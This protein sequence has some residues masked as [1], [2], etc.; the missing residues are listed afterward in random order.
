MDYSDTCVLWYNLNVV[1][2]L[3]IQLHFLDMKRLDKIH[4]WRNLSCGKIVICHQR[5]ETYTF[6]NLN[7]TGQKPDGLFWLEVP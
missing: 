6:Q 2:M 4:S 1:M 3:P 7:N 5:K